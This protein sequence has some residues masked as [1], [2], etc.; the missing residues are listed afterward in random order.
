M[1]HGLIDRIATRGQ[2][3]GMASLTPD[4]RRR[5]TALGFRGFVA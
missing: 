2:A 3:V 5:A 4:L 1:Q